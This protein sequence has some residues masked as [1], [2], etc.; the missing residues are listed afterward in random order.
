MAQP[1]KIIVGLGNPGPDYALTR[2]NIGFMAVDA[3]AAKNAAGGWQRKF[4]GLCASAS[5]G[6]Q[7][8][9]LLKPMTFMNLS[10]ESVGEAMRFYKLSPT[11]VIVFHD[12]IDLLAGKVK[13]KQAGGHAGHNGLKSLDAH[14]GADYWRVRL[15]VGH[16]GDR[17]QVSDYV[18]GS[19]NKSD[20]AWLETLLNAVAQHFP[21][22]L[23]ADD[24]LFMSRIAQDV[25][26]AA[27]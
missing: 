7:D 4:K 12:D 23:A 13:V 24:A 25:K 8:I 21:I 20:A 3:I 22:M 14:I 27:G 1:T 16:P 9:L 19:F 6:K 2:H 5:C 11:D 18:L 15:G 17:A 10:G 26:A